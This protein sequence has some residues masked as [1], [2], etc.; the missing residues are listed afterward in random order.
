MIAG[1]SLRVLGEIAIA[2]VCIAG[3]LAPVLV[4]AR[5]WW[6]RRRKKR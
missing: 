4:D 3:L 2:V 6:P 5:H 1:I